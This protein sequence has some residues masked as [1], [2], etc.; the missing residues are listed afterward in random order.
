MKTCIR[1]DE[2][3]NEEDFYKQGKYRSSFCKECAAFNYKERY[4]PLKDYQN[5]IKRHYALS[6]ESFLDLYKV[7]DGN[8]KICSTPLAMPGK[9]GKRTNTA[10]IDHC[11]ASKKIRGLLCHSCNSGLGYFKDSKEF[12]DKAINYLKNNA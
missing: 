10:Y 9:I 1:C 4:D 5:K 2:D 6:W 3:K 11:H 7:Q 12:L 8:C